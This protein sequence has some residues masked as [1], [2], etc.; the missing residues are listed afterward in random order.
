M[1]LNLQMFANEYV[2]TTGNRTIFIA[3]E[4]SGLTKEEIMTAGSTPVWACLCGEE[5]DT[6]IQ[7][8]TETRN[9]L[10]Y[11]GPVNVKT[12]K[13]LNLNITGAVDI[14]GDA[15][16]YLHKMANS[17]DDEV[18]LVFCT[19]DSLFAETPYYK[20][21]TSRDAVFLTPRTG[22][23]VVEGELTATSGDFDCLT[24]TEEFLPDCFPTIAPIPNAQPLNET[25]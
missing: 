10:C 16:A 17:C 23:A 7:R 6:N 8:E 12:T 11:R 19:M 24:G 22:N 3:I 18:P 15:D 14:T 2:T 1:K 20:I 21:G 25:I 13:L 4:T 9:P 5:A